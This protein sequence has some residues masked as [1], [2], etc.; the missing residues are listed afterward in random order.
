MRISELV[1]RIE[2]L[3]G[4]FEVDERVVSLSWPRFRTSKQR[5]LA[6]RLDRE[7][8]Q[9]GFLI[10]A[11]ILERAQARRWEREVACRCPHSRYAHSPHGTR[12]LK[13]AIQGAIG[14]GVQDARQ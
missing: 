1:L 11:E 12:D 9:N 2:K 8:R 13:K 10:S 4:Q 3:G 5:L 14:P 7:A 6:Q